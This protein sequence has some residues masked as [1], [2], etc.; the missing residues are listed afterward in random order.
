M[1]KLKPCPFC[2]EKEEFAYG[3]SESGGVFV[4]CFI[5]DCRGPE[6]ST[7]K[8]AIAEWNRRYGEE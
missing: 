3:F 5:C 4:W 7:K 8:E 6:S 2:G 1:I